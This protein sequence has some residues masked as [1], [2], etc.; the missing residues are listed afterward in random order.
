M[1]Q[2]SGWAGGGSA[3]AGVGN[4]LLEPALAIRLRVEMMQPL[5]SAT[6]VESSA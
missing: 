1:L 4:A 5:R 6:M 2:Q 3:A